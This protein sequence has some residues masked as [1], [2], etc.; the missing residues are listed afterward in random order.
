MV[1]II[2]SPTLEIFNDWSLHIP[3]LILTS[4]MIACWGI[5]SFLLH[6]LVKTKSWCLGNAV[7]RSPTDAMQKE[8]S[9]KVF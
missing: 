9:I 6:G 2:F 7:L 4:A 3:I 1:A 8:Y 5:G